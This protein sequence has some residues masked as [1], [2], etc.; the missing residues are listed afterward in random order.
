M[1]AFCIRKNNMKWCLLQHSHGV[2]SCAYLH[3]CYCTYAYFFKKSWRSLQVCNTGPLT[4]TIDTHPDMASNI[5]SGD[6][7]IYPEDKGKKQLSQLGYKSKISNLCYSSLE[8]SA[9]VIINVN[10]LVIPNILL[11]IVTKQTSRSL[12]LGHSGVT[13]VLDH[14]AFPIIKSIKKTARVRLDA[15]SC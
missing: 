7:T 13:M 11:N 14:H 2:Y 10:C 15:G 5:F 9:L 6:G 3:I 4:A 12:Y 8:K 1:H